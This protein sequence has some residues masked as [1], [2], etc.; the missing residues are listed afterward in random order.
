[1]KQVN[2]LGIGLSALAAFVAFRQRFNPLWS[3]ELLLHR[4]RFRTLVKPVRVVNKAFTS[5]EAELR[6]KG[7]LRAR[8]AM[9]K[10]FLEIQQFELYLLD[11]KEMLEAE[12]VKEPVGSL[13]PDQEAKKEMIQEE[14][15]WIRPRLFYNGQRFSDLV[16][17]WVDGCW[18]LEV[19]EKPLKQRFHEKELFC[20]LKTGC[21]ARDCGC[22]RRPRRTLNGTQNAVS[23]DVKVHCTIY[24]GCCMRW[25]GLDYFAGSKPEIGM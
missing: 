10:E 9:S 25:Q 3:L 24:C 14:L 5:K 16:S 8:S 18:T 23:P 12:A 20:D 11:E 4:W 13:T 21:C 17:Q 7:Q 2:V 22:C 15:G 1:M 6:E 19:E